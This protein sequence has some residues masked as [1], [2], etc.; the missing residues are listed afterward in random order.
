MS[1]QDKAA[2]LIEEIGNAFE[3]LVRLDIQ[4][5]ITALEIK[6]VN[7][8]GWTLAPKLDA[9]TEGV[10]TVI[11][12][13]Q[14]D[15]RNAISDGALQNAQLLALHADQVKVSRDIVAGNL[16]ALMDLAKSLAR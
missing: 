1:V 16:Q 4:T 13:I 10:S 6:P 9:G 2:A 14:G 12:L 11:D 3:N 7:N 15:I 5:A 8:D